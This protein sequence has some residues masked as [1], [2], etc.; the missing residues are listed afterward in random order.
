[1][2]PGD[3]LTLFLALVATLLV[4]GAGTALAQEAGVAPTDD[5]NIAKNLSYAE[6]LEKAKTKVVEMQTTLDGVIVLME[7]TREKE[8]DV[9]KLN[10]IN[11]NVSSMKGFVKVSEQSVTKLEKA[12]GKKD[13]E[14]AEH[15]YYLVSLA[16]GKV[17]FLAVK[18]RSCAGDVLRYS[19]ETVV[20]KD[21]SGDIAAIDPTNIV[22]EEDVL[23]VI[24]EFTP[25]Q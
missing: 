4:G 16:G 1:M 13:R 14:T 10:C 3:R 22:D 15:Q 20:I 18:A 25:Y 17:A 7:T 21:I 23:F 2:N 8:K 12:I 11:V 5:V 24:E 6:M 9:L 19:G